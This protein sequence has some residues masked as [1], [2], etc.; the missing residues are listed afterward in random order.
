MNPVRRGVTEYYVEC[1]GCGINDV[2]HEY[3]MREAVKTFKTKGW[4]L[5]DYAMCPDCLRE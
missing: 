3:S 5:W 4:G 2:V 1:Y